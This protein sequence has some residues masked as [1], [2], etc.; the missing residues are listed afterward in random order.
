MTDFATLKERVSI[1][2]AVQ[3]LGLQLRPSNH[4]LRGSCPVCKAG[5]D[6]AL[7]VT[8]SKGLFYCF[9]A[10]IG[11]DLITLV[12]H[13]REMPVKDA[14]NELAQH[15]GVG[16][17]KAPAPTAPQENQEG[18]FK[19]LDYLEAE[20]PAVE[21]VGFDAETATALGIG[22]ATKGIMRGTV[23]VPVRLPD[24]MLSG[25]IGITEAKLPSRFRLPNVVP[26]K[27]Q[28]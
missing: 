3:M 27:K 9:N 18:A 16:S 28:A 15:F 13:I 4:Q 20:H 11:G 7:A 26:F 6:R 24:G 14:A 21:A 19:P 1:E 2:Q 5:G 23:A 17:K 10:G 25:Y 22:Y 12:S 8:P